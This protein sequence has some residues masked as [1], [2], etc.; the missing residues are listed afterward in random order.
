VNPT[1]AELSDEMGTVEFALQLEN[2]ASQTYTFAGGALSTP[3]L[4]QTIMS[5]GGIESRHAAVLRGVLGQ[6]QT[7]NVFNPTT[8]AAPEESFVPAS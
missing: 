2:A 1:I 4:R 5:I 6:N 7:P 3:M 8:E